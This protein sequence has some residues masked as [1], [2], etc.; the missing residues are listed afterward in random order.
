MALS[1]ERDGVWLLDVERGRM[2]RIVEDPEVSD[3]LKWLG[4]SGR[5]AYYRLR[6]DGG[7]RTW[8][9]AT[10]RASSAD[11]DGRTMESTLR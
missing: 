1:L 2:R 5:L 3:D 6:P 7:W 9:G 8:R 10:S 4:E 11:E